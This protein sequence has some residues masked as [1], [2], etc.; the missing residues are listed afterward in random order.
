[1]WLIRGMN[2]ATTEATVDNL[3]V[4]TYSIPT[5]KLHRLSTV[6]A[7]L[8][9]RCRRLHIREITLEVT[10]TETVMHDETEVLNQIIKITGQSP[11]LAGWEFAATFEHDAET[12]LTILRA[13]RTFTTPIPEAY[14]HATAVCDHCGYVRRRKDTYLVF[15]ADRNEFKQVGTNCLR[16][17]LGGANIHEVAA[18][19]EA[20]FSITEALGDDS[21]ED[22]GWGSYGGGSINNGPVLP[23]DGFVARSFATV[24]A[25]GFLGRG[26]ARELGGD[27]TANRVLD[28]LMPSRNLMDSRK[29]KADLALTTPTPEDVAQAEAALTW[30]RSWDFENDKLNDYQANLFVAC[31]G[32]TM[33]IRRAGIVASITVAYL[34][35]IERAEE[36]RRAREDAK[37]SVH[38]GTVGER[39]RNLVLTIEHI[40]TSESD[41]GVTHITKMLDASGNVFT[42]FDRTDGT[43]KKGDVVRVTGTVKG[44]TIYREVPQTVLSRVVADPLFPGYEDVEQAGRYV[45]QA[46]E[47]RWAVLEGPA[48]AGAVMFDQKVEARRFLKG[49]AKDCF[50][51]FR[52]MAEYRN[53]EY[54]DLPAPITQPN[55][56]F[57]AAA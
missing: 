21:G 4:A 3:T 47:G 34:R 24:R 14:R 23:M 7:A 31:A 54:V 9:K 5:Y 20:W 6:I 35:H 50:R 12:G 26:K 30:V 56:G 38:Q 57:Q 46:R 51:T 39:L 44:H 17:F 16:D 8:N 10:G 33:P 25:F 18:M 55:L 49:A 36:L 2:E 40:F 19:A 53:L 42:W 27:P 11:K 28:F 41:W 43:H 48:F 37:P 13:N 45:L 22:A 32:E 1:M 52:Q 15:N 29:W